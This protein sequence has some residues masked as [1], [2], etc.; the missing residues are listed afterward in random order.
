[1]DSQ[2]SSAPP[3]TSLTTTILNHRHLHIPASFWANTLR[4]HNISPT[5]PTNSPTATVLST[6]PPRPPQTP[7]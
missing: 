4:P 6:L 5:T 2:D 3:P 1:M 7:L